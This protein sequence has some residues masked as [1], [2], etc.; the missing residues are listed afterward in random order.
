FPEARLVFILR[1]P[2]AR[3]LAGFRSARDWDR[4]IAEG[5]SF[6]DFVRVIAE[7]AD[8]LPVFPADRTRAIYAT[9]AKKVGLYDEIIRHYLEHFA[10]EQMHI[11][12]LD[13]LK[14]DHARSLAAIAHHIG[15]DPARL[16]EAPLT[17]ENQGVEVGNRKL[18]AFARTALA[19]ARDWYRPANHRF[20]DLLADQFPDV[21]QPSWLSEDKT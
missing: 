1:E 16:P 12:F 10:P 2:A 8:P 18:F 11:L 3:L 15:V 20:A 5:V 13:D 14:R 4:N 19:L 7:G 9:D 17:V 21:V 6:L